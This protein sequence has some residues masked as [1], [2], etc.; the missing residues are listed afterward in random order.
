VVEMIPCHPDRTTGN[1]KPVEF[2]SKK[3]KCSAR[4]HAGRSQL[5]TMDGAPNPA[6]G[7]ESQIGSGFASR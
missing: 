4:P 5:T 7:R 3:K 2:F 1:H 6:R